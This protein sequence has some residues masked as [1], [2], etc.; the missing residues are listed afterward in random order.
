MIS[1][2]MIKKFL[3]AS[4]LALLNDNYEMGHFSNREWTNKVISQ[5]LK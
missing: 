5:L 1:I 2:S 3:T 4:S